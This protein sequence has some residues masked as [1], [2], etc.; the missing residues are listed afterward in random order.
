[1]NLLYEAD[2]LN[3]SANSNRR[4]ELNSPK[5]LTHLDLPEPIKRMAKMAAARRGVSVSAYVA[6]LVE[7]EAKTTGVAG[8]VRQ[9]EVAS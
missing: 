1:M 2:R 3:G 9:D 6:A 5:K 7:A 4:S 8:L